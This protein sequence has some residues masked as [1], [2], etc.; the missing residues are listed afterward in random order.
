MFS[1]MVVYFTGCESDQWQCADGSCIP[2]TMRC[3]LVP[4]CEDSSDEQNCR[5]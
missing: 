3:D 5:T 2:A 4:Q 1:N